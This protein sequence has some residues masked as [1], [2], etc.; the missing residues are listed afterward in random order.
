MG[1]IMDWESRAGRAWAVAVTW[2][3]GVGV[4]AREHALSWAQPDI[5]TADP[6]AQVTRLTLPTSLWTRGMGRG[7]DG[8]GRAWANIV[9]ERR[10]AA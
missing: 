9:V 10:C 3:R 2:D 5:F 4:S 6:G 1:A 7:M 8:R